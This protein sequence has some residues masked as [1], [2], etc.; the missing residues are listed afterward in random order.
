MS[1]QE[2]TNLYN[3][4][5]RITGI[6]KARE[7]QLHE[8]KQALTDIKNWDEDLADEWEDQEERASTALYI[9]SEIKI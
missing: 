3:Q 5:N 1:E 6:L 2:R 9:I 7:S 4:I 8:A